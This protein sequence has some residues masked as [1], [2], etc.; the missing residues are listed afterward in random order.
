M[1]VT[2][3]PHQRAL[4]QLLPSGLAW[5]KAPDSLLASLC[6]ALSQATARVSW[7]ADQLLEERFPDRARW[8]LPDWERFLGLPDCDMTDAGTDERQTAAANKLR[9]KPSLNRAFYIALAAAYGFRI[10]IAT[11]ADSQWVS[12]VTVLDTISYRNMTVLDNILTP[13]RVY[14]A[15]VLECI[16]NRYKPAHQEFRYVYS[17]TLAGHPVP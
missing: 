1:A 2:L 7:D 4:L 11:A 3:T 17:E 5:N 12:I 10:D 14:D 6:G 16:L 8:L 15:G 13:L 9:M